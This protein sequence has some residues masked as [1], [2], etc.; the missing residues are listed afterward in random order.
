MFGK[1]LRQSRQPLL[2]PHSY[3]IIDEADEMLHSD[4][5][6]EMAKVMSGGGKQNYATYLNRHH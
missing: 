5:E 3:T 6:N 1:P 2:T 4:W